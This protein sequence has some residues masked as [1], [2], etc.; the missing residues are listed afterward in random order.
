[1]RYRSMG[2]SG[3]V[4]SAISLSLASDPARP[5]ASDWTAY[6]YAALEH[7]VSTFEVSGHD[8]VV[9]GGLAEAVSAVDRRLLFV[10]WRLGSGGGPRDFS[11]AGLTNQV[12]A[13]IARTGLQ[14]LDAVVLD[15]PGA[16][17]LLPASLQVL[18]DLKTSGAARFIGLGGEG[19][20]IDDHIAAGGLDLLI[21][22]FNLTSGWSDR[23]RIRAALAGDM[24]VV[25]Y[26]A[27]PRDFHAQVAAASRS[28]ITM[29]MPAAKPSSPP[30]G[31]P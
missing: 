15:E 12:R 23:N 10:S 29:T 30:R 18:V 24:A 31:P 26:R 4:V 13:A 11:P 25:G 8:P 22:P 3:A 17:E 2:P 14:Y 9:I 5:R 20:P 28:A 19:A 6:I 21:V 27:Y 1:M 16:D 7:G